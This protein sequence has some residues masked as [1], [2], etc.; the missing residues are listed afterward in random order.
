MNSQKLKQQKPVT[1]AEKAL[2]YAEKASAIVRQRAHS[3]PENEVYSRIISEIEYVKTV[4]I[5]PSTDR[6]RLH[7]FTFGVGGGDASEELERRDPELLD[8]LGGMLWIADKIGQGL[9]MNSQ[10][11]EEFLQAPRNKS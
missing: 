8:T 7:K 11:L 5:E 1:H 6:S 4:L 2:E 10:V 3:N 9:K